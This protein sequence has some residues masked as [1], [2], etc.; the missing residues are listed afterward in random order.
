MRI[1]ESAERQ[2]G[3]LPWVV[4]R[5]APRTLS[6]FGMTDEPL[7]QL[8]SR[9]V[10]AF[11][12]IGNPDGFRRTLEP[13]CGALAGFRRFP[14]HYN[15]QAADVAE[16]T[17]WLRSLNADLAL[18]TQKDLVKLRAASL[19]GVPL[20]ALR[21]ELDIMEGAERLEAALAALLPSRETDKDD[22]CLPTRPDGPNPST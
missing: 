5:H 13:L 20:R 8:R 14:D 2:A 7:S 9:T 1:R 16:L 15:Y 6:G 4:T 3:P 12:G 10:A 18:T 22:P 19:G 17:R 11:C 21:I